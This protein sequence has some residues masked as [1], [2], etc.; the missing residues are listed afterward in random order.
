MS[1]F[2]M[3]RRSSGPSLGSNQRKKLPLPIVM[4]LFALSC[5]ISGSSPPIASPS[6]IR[7]LVSLPF[8]EVVEGVEDAS[9]STTGADSSLNDV[10]VDI[11]L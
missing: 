1:S 7:T 2:V 5:L 10:E 8:E 6:E 11:S 3:R 9:S 4:F